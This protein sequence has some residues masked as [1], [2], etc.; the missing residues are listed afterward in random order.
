M[1]EGHWI[2]SGYQVNVMFILSESWSPG[3]WKTEN[4]FMVCLQTTELKRETGRLLHTKGTAIGEGL[5]MHTTCAFTFFESDTFFRILASKRICM[6]VEVFQN[7]AR[8]KKIHVS[9]SPEQ[10]IELAKVRMQSGNAWE[11]QRAV[12]GPSRMLVHFYQAYGL[13][14]V[15]WLPKARIR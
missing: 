9:F 6:N 3:L 14:Q 12:T 11:V 5:V 4:I 10:L 1:E 15:K 8:R 7:K 2:F 13:F